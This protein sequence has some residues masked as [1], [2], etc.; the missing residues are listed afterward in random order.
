MNT[1]LLTVAG[2][3]REPFPEDWED[4]GGPESGPRIVGHGAGDCW[5]FDGWEVIIIDNEV[6]Q[7]GRVPP[8]PPGFGEW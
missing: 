4:I 7:Y 6:V 5:T 2:Y 1:T 3:I 8:E